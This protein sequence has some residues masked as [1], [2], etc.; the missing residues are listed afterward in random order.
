MSFPQ[1]SAD[2]R[3]QQLE[4]TVMRLQTHV[5]DLTRELQSARTQREE[6]QERL[7]NHESQTDMHLVLQEERVDSLETRVTEIDGG[8]P[9]L[10]QDEQQDDSD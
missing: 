8:G 6:L 5:A 3:L 7:T 1:P 2:Q 9:C 10:Q 4:S